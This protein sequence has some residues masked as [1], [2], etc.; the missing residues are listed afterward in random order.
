MDGKGK[1]VKIDL[2]GVDD[3]LFKRLRS[4]L[5]N[6]IDRF[7]DTTV[8]Y[9]T[10]TN[11]RDETK[12]F[13]S[14]ALNYAEENLKKTGIENHKLIAEIEEKYSIAEKNKAEARKIN[15]EAKQ[16]EFDQSV[17]QLVLSLKLTKALILG[18]EGKESV[19]LTQQIELFLETLENAKNNT[20]FLE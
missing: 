17:D 10:R 5:L 19:V 16:L 1:L 7:L 4:K 9:Q 15:A 12:R 20:H 14:L 3:K 8:D 13:A 18:K 6:A 2:T 11:I